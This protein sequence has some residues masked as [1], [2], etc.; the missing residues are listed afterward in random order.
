[1]F[2]HHQIVLA[3]NC[4]TASFQG[5]GLETYTE[6]LHSDTIKTCGVIVKAYTKDGAANL[7][8][9]VCKKDGSGCWDF[10]GSFNPS[11]TSPYSCFDGSAKFSG[12]VQEVV[13]KILCTDSSNCNYEALLQDYGGDCSG[14]GG[15]G[16]SGG[17]SP[18]GSSGGSGST[19]SPFSGLLDGSPVCDN[20]GDLPEGCTCNKGKHDGFQLDCGINIPILDHTINLVAD[21]AIC[22]DPATVTI[23]IVDSEDVCCLLVLVALCVPH[24]L[25]LCLF[26]LCIYYALLMCRTSTIPWTRFHPA[27]T[28]I[29]PS[30]ELQFVRMGH[31]DVK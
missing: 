3:Q 11:P 2:L 27:R 21:F 17:G 15:G 13:V 4:N 8:V 23:K 20:L 24:T 31:W 6:S 12:G 19:N 28:S 7:D 9:S 22:D 10:E 14:G 1:M 25:S 16:S 29:S 26:G 18:G 30:Q 5:K